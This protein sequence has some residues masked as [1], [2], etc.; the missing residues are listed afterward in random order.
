MADPHC[1][2]ARIRKLLRGSGREAVPRPAAHAKRRSSGQRAC[3]RAGTRRLAP[4]V[5]RRSSCGRLYVAAWS[6][7]V[8]VV[9]VTA[10]PF[11]FSGLAVQ[12]L[13]AAVD[14]AGRSSARTCSRAPTRRSFRPSVAPALSGQERQSEGP[15]HGNYSFRR[16]AMAGGSTRFPALT[17]GSGRPTDPPSRNSSQIFAGLAA[18]ILVI[19]CANLAGLLLAR[20]TER[21]R[22]LA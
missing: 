2:R 6:S 22:E 5:R 21:G 12:L 15:D 11:P 17:C 3:R 14:G 8:T 13:A 16:A 18:A 7:T 19:A 20:A 10:P 4:D 1:G 9:G